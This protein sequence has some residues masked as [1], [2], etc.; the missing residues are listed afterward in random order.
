VFQRA[1]GDLS[2]ISDAALDARLH[3]LAVDLALADAA[4]SAPSAERKRSRKV[5][6]GVG[7]TVAGILFGAQT[8]GLT[9]LLCVPGIADLIDVLE[10]DAAALRLQVRLRS[11]IERFN[12]VYQRI[13]VEKANRDW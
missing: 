5:F 11:D 12:V 4:I 8:G 3:E 13:A 9:L 1:P 10:E 6:R 7:L 2:T